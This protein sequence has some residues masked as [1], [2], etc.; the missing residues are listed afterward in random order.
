MNNVNKTMYIPLYGKS[1]VSKKG[2]FLEDKKA[3][4]IWQAEGFTLKGKAKSKWLAY[5][6]GI[7]A[8]VFDEWTKEKMRQF[9]DAVI[10]HLGCGMDS[11]AERIGDTTHLWY[12]VDFQE[13]IEE[14]KRYFTP[15]TTYQM[16][17]ADV[18]HGGWLNDI[19]KVKNAIIVMEGI[20]MYLTNAQLKDI[21]CAISAHFDSVAVLMD[22]YTPTAAK[23]SKYKNPVR[24][25]GVKQV[26]GIGNPQDVENSD[27]VFIDE[28]QMTPQSYIDELKGM[29]KW[30]FRKL[31][32]GSFSKKLY[33]LYEYNK[34]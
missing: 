31:Y 6:M 29:E 28:K 21:L 24:G 15:S 1:Y 20:T 19:P 7:R 4:E 8:A 9:P 25:V 30:I 12:D 17:S 32:A 16:L 3:E 27:L 5:Y 23:F 34:K 18:R 14:R 13:V 22:C 33:K 26:Y 10:L 2:L 11:R